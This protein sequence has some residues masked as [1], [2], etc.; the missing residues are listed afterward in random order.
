[1]KS[2]K[3]HRRPAHILALESSRAG[4]HTAE[5][6]SGAQASYDPRVIAYRDAGTW[7]TGRYTPFVRVEVVTALNAKG[8]EFQY[9]MAMI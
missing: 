8:E 9:S 2:L 4:S 7:I 3:K 5:V 1:M 6:Q